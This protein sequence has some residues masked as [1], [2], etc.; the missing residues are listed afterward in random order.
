MLK[1]ALG[2]ITRNLTSDDALMCFIEN[3]EKFGHKLDSVIVA[4][5]HTLDPQVADSLNKKVPFCSIDIKDPRFCAEQL[6]RIG[7]SGKAARTLLDCPVDPRQ[8]LM[9]YGFKRTL[10]T[11]EAI[12]RGMDILFFVD[13]DVIPSVLKAAPDG[14]A[15]EEAD[16]FGAHLEH[17]NAGSQVTTGEYS[18]YN[19]LPPALFDG[20]DD[21]LFGLQK[22]GV[23][24]YWKDS[25][26]HR[27]LALQPAE[28][29]PKPCSKI[30]GGNCAF[31]LS[32]F[33]GL[34]PFFSSYYT[35]NGEL[36]LNRGEDTVLGLGIEKSGTVCTDIGLNPMHDTYKNYPAVPD[37]RGSSAD[38]ERF[39][40]ACTGWVGR[41]PLYNYVRGE[42]MKLA[43]DH[44]RERLES[45]LR[46]LADFTSNKKFLSVL[47][48]FDVSWDNLGRYINE[49]ESVLASWEEFIKRS[50]ITA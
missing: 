35:H 45:G 4:Y 42:D 5:T 7:V 38:Q 10:L 27:C 31:K 13:S 29:E 11:A 44:R 9:P 20:M 1:T 43:R 16:F 36:F 2:M 22:E 39:Y 48:N 40:Y 26:S 19:I 8:G 23:L 24:D 21:L 32:A 41:N 47:E 3:A 18:G 12:L 34:P 14:P 33:A 17:L 28:R 30:L 6:K 50:D 15:L 25:G 46:A 49:Y 37:L